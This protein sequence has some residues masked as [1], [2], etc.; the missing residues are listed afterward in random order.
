MFHQNVSVIGS[1][2]QDG[3]GFMA[4]QSFI[5]SFSVN[6]KNAKKIERVLNSQKKIIF[7]KDFSVEYVNHA[8]IREFLGLGQK[9]NSA[10]R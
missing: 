5:K 8:K 6:R 2:E 7:T 10:E 4:T 9:E 1:Y 3:G